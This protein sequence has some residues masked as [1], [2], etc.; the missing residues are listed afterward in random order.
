M[1]DNAIGDKV[2]IN[3]F[4]ISGRSVYVKAFEVSSVF[5]QNINLNAVSPGMYLVRIVD[6]NRR[7]TQ[8]IIVK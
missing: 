4:D 6:G 5:N 7:V 2:N 1:F 3:V 8:K